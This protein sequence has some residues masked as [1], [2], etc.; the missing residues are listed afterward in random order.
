[1]YL[2]FRGWRDVQG[3]FLGSR[4][5]DHSFN[6]WMISYQAH[7]VSHLDNPFFTTLQNA[8][9]GVNL[10]ANVGL[11]VPG[12][13]LAPLTLL[14]GPEYTYLVVMTLNLAATGFAW[15]WVL[16]RHLLRS[17][18]A[19]L[20]GGLFCAFAPAMV[21][22]S[23][24]HPHITAQYLVP[25]IVLQVVRLTEPGRTVRRGLVLAALV[26]AQFYL[27]LE[28][29]LLV[30]VGCAFA[31]V[32]YLLVRPRAAVRALPAALASLAVT[33]GTVLVLVAYPL[34]M[35]YFGPQSR[36][37]HPGNPDVYALTLKAFVG[38]P[39][40]S[41]AGGPGV[42]RDSTANTTEE[43]AY[44]GWPVLVLALAATAVLWRRLVG[45]RVLALVAVASGMLAIGTT[46]A[47]TRA[48]RGDAP[49]PFRLVEHLPP[50]DAIVV[51]RF[52][53]IT[54]VAL[55][56]LLA[57]AADRMVF[58]GDLIR[59]KPARLVIGGVLV[60]ALLPIVPT[61]LA[62][63]PR[64]AIPA[65]VTSGGW[66]QFVGEGRTLVPVP[67]DGLRSIRW[68]SAGGAGFAVPQGYFVGPTSATDKTGRWG[69]E[70]RPTA[71]LLTA[72][73]TGKR[74]PEVTAAERA[75]AV[76][77]ARF[78][79]ADAFVLDPLQDRGPLRQAMRGLY[80]PGRL[81]DGV[82]VWDVRSL[83]N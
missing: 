26:A 72:V 63:S 80:G 40:L 83:T 23:N 43:T 33:A 29:L 3:V 52:A 81:V 53:L 11:Q 59:A 7:A 22:Q 13:L 15:Y 2:T 8:P 32:A 57:V 66:R 48:D 39:T 56:V 9:D 75:Q 31:A 64:P 71:A 78:W 17:R 73:S 74:P 58:T 16:S 47:W 37:G 19:A 67:V 50:F 14:A 18:A 1:M 36:G 21:S 35:M 45:V 54:T 68:G 65:F 41:L 42:T 25:F 77:D 34:W 60:A 76:A 27:G 28:V 62:A 51:A 44:Y 24:G 12:I 69:V 79:R 46:W 5:G 4:P 82:W 55:G 61:P 38:W 10:V 30:A 20:L 49:A 6:E 70:P